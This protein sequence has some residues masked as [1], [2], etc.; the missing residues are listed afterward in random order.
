MRL[1]RGRFRLLLDRGG[2]SSNI[3]SRVILLFS[4]SVGV[5]PRNSRRYYGNPP[6][7]PRSECVERGSFLDISLTLYNPPEGI[8]V[9]RFSLGRE[10]R[11][12]FTFLSLSFRRTVNEGE[13]VSPLSVIRRSHEVPFLRLRA[14]LLFSPSALFFSSWSIS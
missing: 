1:L 11:P 12:S 8:S 14:F 13:R 10:N 2:P 5:F 6:P 4:L 3:F 9:E 7:P